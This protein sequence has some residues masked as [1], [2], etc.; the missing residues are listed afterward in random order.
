MSIDPNRTF[1]REPVETWQGWNRYD[2]SGAWVQPSPD[3][4]PSAENTRAAYEVL[5]QIDANPEA[6][7]QGMWWCNTG[8]CFAGWR[9]V[10]SG[11]KPKMT[12][13]DSYPTNLPFMV[14]SGVE[15]A[16]RAAQLLGFPSADA[17]NAYADRV[18]P[19]GYSHLFAPTNTRDDLERLVLA[20]FGP[21]P[22]GM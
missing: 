18:G 2:I 1:V 15:I 3:W 4:H 12:T 13:D 22:D 7:Q 5:D 6:W 9:C 14:E 10:L 21:R 20:I 16:D 11:E 17:L 8:G 19:D